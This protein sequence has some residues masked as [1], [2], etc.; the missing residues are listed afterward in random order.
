MTVATVIY[1]A[2]AANIQLS[3]PDYVFLPESY[4]VE[5]NPG[6]LMTKSY[7]IAF[8][9]ESNEELHNCKIINFE[10]D[11]SVIVVNKLAS[12]F[13]NRPLRSSVEKMIVEDSYLIIKGIYNDLTLGETATFCS[14]R[15]Q[16]GIEY[17]TS[18]DGTERYLSIIL[19][20]AVKYQDIF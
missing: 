4:I 7:A 18:K 8:G 17:V 2:L 1:D 3:L 20:I 16:S 12:T 11:F 9:Q 14:Y 13:N 10:R 15:G 19:N 5:E 6:Y